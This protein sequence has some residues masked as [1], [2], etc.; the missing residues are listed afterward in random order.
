[1]ILIATP[2]KDMVNAG[3]AYDLANLISWTPSAVFSIAQGS[4][5][6]NVR[7][8]L[9]NTAIQNKA[10]HIMFI[11]SDMRFPADIVKNLMKRNLDIVGANCKQRTRDEWTARKDGEFIGSQDEKGVEEI[12]TIGM[13]ATLIRIGVFEKMV[14]PYFSMPWDDKEKKHVGEDVYFCMKA[15]EAGFKIFIDH[16][17][18]QK[19]KHAALIEFGL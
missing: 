16:D 2:T 9:A 18:S 12:D 5:L 1:M 19:V 4:I 11:D 17:V 3:F 13:G 8:L 15:K 7:E 10:T 14:E 6:P